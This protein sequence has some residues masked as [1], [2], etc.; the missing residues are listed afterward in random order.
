MLG[1]S[2][3]PLD[4]V[5]HFDMPVGWTEMNGRNWLKHQ[6]IQIGPDCEAKKMSLYTKLNACCLEGKCWPCIK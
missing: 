4:Y 2:V 3:I 6:A 5:T 1:V